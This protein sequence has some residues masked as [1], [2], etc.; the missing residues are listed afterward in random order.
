MLV[1][2]QLEVG[3][4]NN[5]S[6]LGH[7]FLLGSFLTQ[8][9]L[10][11]SGPATGSLSGALAGEPVVGGSRSPAVPKS[12]VCCSGTAQASV[13]KSVDGLSAG[14]EGGHSSVGGW[15]GWFGLRETLT[16]QPYRLGK[17]GGWRE[18]SSLLNGNRR[19]R[20]FMFVLLKKS[21]VPFVFDEQAIL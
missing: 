7:S 5:I 20:Y 2:K 10:V 17:R 11:R 19:W 1:N 3:K 12:G 18:Q 21:T 6:A 13:R 4:Y 9:E 8:L 16:P 15:G 14:Q